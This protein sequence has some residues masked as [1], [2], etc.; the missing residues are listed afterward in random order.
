MHGISIK[1]RQYNSIYKMHFMHL[2]FL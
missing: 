1:N 2:I